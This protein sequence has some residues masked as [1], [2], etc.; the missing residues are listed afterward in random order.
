MMF[1]HAMCP[2]SPAYH[3]T[4]VVRLSGTVDEGLLCAAAARLCECHEL[5]RSEFVTDQYG[6]TRCRVVAMAKSPLVVR[7]LR[8]LPTAERAS[9]ADKW[10]NEQLLLPFDLASAPLWRLA[11]VRL[12]SDRAVLALVMHHI[13]A[14]GWSLG[15]VRRNLYEIYDALRLGRPLPESGAPPAVY[16]RFVAA[17]RAWARAPEEESGLAYWRGQL[18]GLPQIDLPMAR[19]RPPV[20]RF[21]GRHFDVNIDEKTTARLE[22][23]ARRSGCSLYMVLAA[24]FASV[25]HRYSGQPD[26]AFGTPVANRVDAEF[27]EAVGLFVNTVVLRMDMTGNPGFDAVLERTRKVVLDALQHQRTPFE[28][29]V[30]DLR[31][32]RA[33][34]HNPLF[35]VMFALQNAA[36]GRLELPGTRAEPGA[37]DLD[38]ARFDLECTLWRHHQGLRLRLNYRE[39]LFD[40]QVARQ[41]TDTYLR[42]LSEASARPA[43][44]VSR[45][46]VFPAASYG[47][48]WSA[49]PPA[50]KP[51]TLPELFRAVVER[52]P[53]AVAITDSNETLI[54]SE[55]H[56]R[57]EA[58]GHELRRRGIT[59]GR[60]AAVCTDRTTDLVV[61]TLAVA[62]S[63][64]AFLPLNPNDPEDRVR[65]ILEDAGAALVL[66]D[67]SRPVV[68]AAGFPAL[69]V[70]ASANLEIGP[71]PPDDPHPGDL[72]YVLYTS[73][74]TGRPKGVAVEHRNLCNTLR[75]CQK[76]FGFG[77]WDTG[78]VLAPSTFDVFYYELLSCLLAGGRSRLV[79]REELFDPV[80]ITTLLGKATAF[81]AVP[82]LMQHLLGALEQQGITSVPGMRVVVT[83][84]DLVPAPLLTRLTEVFA[85]A[86][87]AVTYGPTEAAIFA[88]GYTV[89]RR[90][91]PIGHPIGEPLAGV[92]IMVADERG[93]RLPD[94]VAGEIWI[95][96]RG[97]ARGYVNLEKE[98]SKRFVRRS[99]RRYY[100][101]GDR[102]R[103]RREDGVLEFLGR[104]D[105]Q[106]KIRG[107]RIELGEVEAVLAQAPGVYSAVVV[108]VGDTPAERRLV[109]YVVPDQ[110]AATTHDAEEVVGQWRALFD[111]THE[112]GDPADRDFSGWNSSYDGRPIPAE[113]MTEWLD[114]TLAAIRETLAGIGTCTLRILEIGCGIGL[115]LLKLAGDCESYVGVDFSAS[116]LKA[117][118]RRI[119]RKGLRNVELH[120]ADA[121]R[122]PDVGTD[123]D[124]VVVN[125]VAQYLPDVERLTA[126]LDGALARTRAGGCVFVG[127]VRSLPLLETFHV[128]VE[129]RRLEDPVGVLA[130]A[131]QRASQENELVVSPA[132]FTEY[133]AKQRDTACSAGPRRGRIANELTKYRYD[134]VLWKGGG[135]QIARYIWRHWS[136][137]GWDSAR[138]AAW[139]VGRR[140][141]L[142]FQAI[143]HALVQADVERHRVLQETAGA[144]PPRPVARGTPAVP[145]GLREIGE[146]HG[147]H[148]SF[149][150]ARSTDDGSFDAVFEPVETRRGRMPDWPTAPTY[151]ARANSP[152]DRLADRRLVGEVRERLAARLPVYMLPSAICV[153]DALPYTANNK[154]DR[155]LLPPVELT[156]ADGRPPKTATEVTVANVWARTLGIA[157]PSATDDFFAAGGTSLLAIRTTVELNRRGLRVT[158]QQI[159]ELRTVERIARTLDKATASPESAP[160]GPRPAADIVRVAPGDGVPDSMPGPDLWQDVRRVLLTGATGMLGVHVLD[161]ALRHLPGLSLTC[162]VRGGDAGSARHRLFEQYRWYFPDSP[163]NAARFAER[164]RVLPG[165]LAA[166]RLGLSDRDR[167]AARD[168]DAIVHT[169]ADV[170]HVAPASEIRAVN[171]QGTRRLLELCA[172]MPRPRFCH[173]STIGVAGKAS[174]GGRRV[175]DE[176]DLEIGQIPTEPYSASKL[177]AERLIR[178]FGVDQDA[179]M[180]LRVGTVA[181]H[182]VTGRFQRNI[183]A[184]FLSRYLRAVLALGMCPDWRSRYFALIPADVMAHM[185]WRLSG[186]S[187]AWGRSF[188][189]QSPHRLGHAE[190]AAILVDLGYSVRL[191]APEDIA[192]VVATLGDDPDT[193]EDVGRILPMLQPQPDL[194][195]LRWNRTASWLEQ[196]GLRYPEPTAEWIGRFVRHGVKLGFFPG[197][198]GRLGRDQ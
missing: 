75:A 94:G 120:Q 50:V 5:L 111:R 161:H 83:G 10:I 93:T 24:G 36:T 60:V 188:H 129:D 73:G 99:G 107:F 106:V 43:D 53:D 110:R 105:N 39:D 29:I 169:A 173:I 18:A 85:N 162:L 57:T 179:A 14:D 192:A 82:G 31:P 149:S 184:H 34:S 69:D 25:L 193:V 52:F 167:R 134:V 165:D 140:E 2:D 177:E 187:E 172:S 113:E 19:T 62:M 20:A 166:D 65:F 181:P 108:P 51:T 54:L 30:D 98:T 70:T 126:V 176:D 135:V 15:V 42:L 13:I 84:G 196:L 91:S 100:R 80:A 95:G 76:Y 61:A 143:P 123:F 81:Q 9:A 195:E 72:A 159:F 67:R 48:V 63:G 133:A 116:A 148:V 41:F 127:D 182:S 146:R 97:V 64:A 130:R 38:I 16:A 189:I 170:R 171:V 37:S 152:R 11:L 46:E 58:L 145:D 131:T 1:L 56:H 160:A 35:Q 3:I 96:G 26:I 101:S 109:A 49:P 197:R 124:L 150:W 118:R 78:L 22:A 125:S 132:F 156:D 27:A 114:G 6:R 28:R 163:I 180:V 190:L 138:L 155:T 40:K 74:T 33:L 115:V 4:D 153:L 198:R 104:A 186:Q 68:A 90:C 178:D 168:C 102:G 122:L 141:P 119:L 151:A 21:I 92:E 47:E 103:R 45:L 144:H 112:H 185:V 87:V 59:R 86:R 44:P 77:P 89:D 88:T 164:V 137:D 32:E 158:P 7:D 183:D 66:V 157:E 139:L 147:Y 12:A 175:F 79:G 136:Q 55:L 117:T 154:V 23:L 8:H 142:A 174:P 121:A 128:S 194:V 71:E 17:E 191:M